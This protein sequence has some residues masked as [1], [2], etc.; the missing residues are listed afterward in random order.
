MRRQR[1]NAHGRVFRNRTIFHLIE[2]DAPPYC[3]FSRPNSGTN[4]TSYPFDRFIYLARYPFIGNKLISLGRLTWRKNR[5]KSGRF[6]FFQYSKMKEIG[7]SQIVQIKYSTIGDLWLRWPRFLV[8]LQ[9]RARLLLLH[10]RD[11]TL[12][13][14]FVHNGLAA[15][16]YRGMRRQISLFLHERPD[17]MHRSRPNN[18]PLWVAIVGRPLG[19]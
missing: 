12:L 13:P 2:A 17:P 7:D 1:Y 6:Q 4:R 16:D 14:Q 3:H 11:L 18:D 15:T 8:K 19:L 5:S 9:I 10:R